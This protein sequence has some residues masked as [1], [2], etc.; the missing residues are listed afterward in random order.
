MFGHLKINW[1]NFFSARSFR[2]SRSGG[3][4][5]KCKEQTRRNSSRYTLV[6]FNL[7]I[8]NVNPY[9]STDICEDPELKERIMQ[10]KTEQETKRQ[11]EAQKRRVRRSQSNTRTQSVRRTSLR[12]KGLTARRDAVEEARMRME[13]EHQVRQKFWMADLKGEKCSLR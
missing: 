12:D 13:A 1:S 3:R 5:F 11:A 9:F 6:I 10:L 7:P 4:W 2:A 8:W